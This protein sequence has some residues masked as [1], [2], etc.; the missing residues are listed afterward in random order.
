MSHFISFQAKEHARKAEHA[1]EHAD[2]LEL[3][4]AAAEHARKAEHADKLEL[5]LA[6]AEHAAAEHAR[7]LELLYAQR[8]KVEFLIYVLE[9]C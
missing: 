6:E 8:G 3:L 1:A 5:L 2:K 4:Q 9:I 7:R